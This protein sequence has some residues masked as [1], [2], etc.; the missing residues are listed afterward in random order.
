MPEQMASFFRDEKLFSIKRDGTTFVETMR[1]DGVDTEIRLPPF[2]NE[3][4]W[5][6]KEQDP[7]FH[8]K[9][10]NPYLTNGVSHHYHLGKPIFILGASGVNFNF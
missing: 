1:I 2:D 3:I 5:K 6:D 7:I 4:E 8:V 9:V 10:L